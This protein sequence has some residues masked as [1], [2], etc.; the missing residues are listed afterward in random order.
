MFDRNETRKLKVAVLWWVCYFALLHMQPHG[1]LRWTVEGE[2]VLADDLIDL[3]VSALPKFFPLV[4]RL[5][6]RFEV[7]P[8]QRDRR[9]QA[10]RPNVKGLPFQPI[11]HRARH[12]PRVISGQAERH[13]RLSSA[14]MNA[15]F[16]K[17]FAGFFAI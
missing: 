13:E 14:I 8:C 6:D 1:L 11:D 17:D 7:S 3:C 5:S 12:A 4:F 16:C 15:V 2:V 10:L 9:P